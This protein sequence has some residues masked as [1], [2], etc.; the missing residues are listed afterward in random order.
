MRRDPAAGGYSAKQ[1]TGDIERVL[2]HL[3]IGSYA[4]FGYSLNG[5]VASS[6]ALGNPRVKAVVCGG[7]PTA[8]SYAGV[9]KPGSTDGPAGWGRGSRR[10]LLGFRG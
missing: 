10:L 4:A 2:D 8:G 9:A 7:F 3:D 5:A 1:I 6:L